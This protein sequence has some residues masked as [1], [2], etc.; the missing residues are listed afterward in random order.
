MS[1]DRKKW[2]KSEAIWGCLKIRDPKTDRSLTYEIPNSKPLQRYLSL[3]HPK[4]KRPCRQNAKQAFYRLALTLVW[5]TRHLHNSSIRLPLSASARHSPKHVWSVWI[6]W[7]KELE[8]YFCQILK[9][10]VNSPYQT[11][12]KQTN[13]IDEYFLLKER[14]VKSLEWLVW[15]SQEGTTHLPNLGFPRKGWISPCSSFS[16]SVSKLCL[17]H[18]TMP[19]VWIWMETASRKNRTHH[20]LAL[21]SGHATATAI[22]H[23]HRYREGFNHLLQAEWFLWNN[24]KSVDDLMISDRRQISARHFS[25]ESFYIRVHPLIQTR[26]SMYVF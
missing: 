5:T 2:T 19:W 20:V 18:K 25:F 7:V 3:R 26:P 15:T 13:F 14:V 1:S 24:A 8:F 6:H 4:L 23:I 10:T 17:L 22:R 21:E 11:I 12:W 9:L 16:N